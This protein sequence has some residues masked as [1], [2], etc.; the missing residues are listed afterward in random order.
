MIKVSIIASF[1]FFVSLEVAY[2][3]SGKVTLAC[4]TDGFFSNV[5]G[6]REEPDGI[7]DST[8]I[9]ELLYNDGVIVNVSSPWACTQSTIALSIDDRMIIFSCDIGSEG[10]RARATID[11]YTG[12]YENISQFL[13]TG[14]MFR[15]VGFCTFANRQF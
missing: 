3:Q 11:R 7:Y 4:Q 13:N 14:G 12:E 15:T 2:A 10:H 6:L 9:W 1:L 5:P 8:A